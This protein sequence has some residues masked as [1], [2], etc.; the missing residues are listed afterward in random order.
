MRTSLTRSVSFHARH[1]YAAPD[2]GGGGANGD[3][4]HLYRIDITVEATGGP[5]SSVIDLAVFDALIAEEIVAPLDGRHLNE[6]VAEFA[7]GAEP[8]T[9]EALAMWCWRRVAHRLPPGV[10]LDCVRVAEDDSLA[11]EC[12][13][14]G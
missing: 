9:C 1:R 8:P 6:V 14:A 13:D 11:A 7:A 4:G 10:R 5:R 3:H 2:G 12:R